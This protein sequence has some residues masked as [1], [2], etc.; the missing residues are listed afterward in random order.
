ME[1]TKLTKSLA[2][3][4]MLRLIIVVIVV[5]L[6][7]AAVIGVISYANLVNEVRNYTYEAALKGSAVTSSDKEADDNGIEKIFKHRKARRKL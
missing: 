2:F 3:K 4:T 1:K 7:A 6:I 5:S